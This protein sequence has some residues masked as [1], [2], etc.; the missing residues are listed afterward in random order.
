MKG[1]LQAFSAAFFVF[2]AVGYYQAWQQRR[3]E[4]EYSPIVASTAERIDP[5]RENALHAPTFI[6]HCGSQEVF[7]YDINSESF[8]NVRGKPVPPIF[9][10]QG[11]L[12]NVEVAALVTGVNAPQI[13]GMV[14]SGKGLSTREIIAGVVGAI[15]GYHL[16]KWLGKATRPSCGSDEMLRFIQTQ[17]EQ[18][19]KDLG[20]ALVRRELNRYWIVEVGSSGSLVVDKANLNSLRR[21][22]DSLPEG[23]IPLLGNALIFKPGLPSRDELEY[24]CDGLSRLQ[25]R[26]GQPNYRANA[27]DFEIA[28]WSRMLVL[29]ANKSQVRQKAFPNLYR[30]VDSRELE[31]AYLGMLQN[32]LSFADTAFMQAAYVGMFVIGGVVV[33]IAIPV[34]VYTLCEWY[35]DLAQSK[36][37]PRPASRAGGKSVSHH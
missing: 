3:H 2:L 26:M 8:V 19:G 7:E 6:Y 9:H 36:R 31:E 11:N 22:A 13:I 27:E 20:N 12:S 5:Y 21:V 32:Y 17:P 25:D 10:L 30:V 35:T 1:I 4:S 34:G 28:Q 15:A 16:G 37:R 18:F 24:V 23:G 14:R 33:L 29:W